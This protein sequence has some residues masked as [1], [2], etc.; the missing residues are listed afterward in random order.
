MQWKLNTLVEGATYRT[1]NEKTTYYKISP[2]ESPYV[3]SKF[4]QKQ[5]SDHIF[6][7]YSKGVTPNISN[8][9]PLIP[10]VYYLNIF[11]K[12]ERTF[13]VNRGKTLS[14]NEVVRKYMLTKN[15][16]LRRVESRFLTKAVE[17][18]I[19]SEQRYHF[20]VEGCIK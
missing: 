6:R 12:M 8:E 2:D 9:K 14:V 1:I 20:M 16:T 17:D 19:L 3:L 13:S 18:W 15:V 4:Q 7:L 5:E 10:Y 11:N